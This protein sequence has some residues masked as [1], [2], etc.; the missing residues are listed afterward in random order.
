MLLKLAN[1]RRNRCVPIV[2]QTLRIPVHQVFNGWRAVHY[3]APKIIATPQ[4][5]TTQQVAT[6]ATGMDII[7]R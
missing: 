6:H 7:P 5:M 4:M 3:I 1:V 2:R